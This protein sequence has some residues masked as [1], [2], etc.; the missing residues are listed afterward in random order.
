MANKQWSEDK[1]DQ[2]DDLQDKLKRASL[3]SNENLETKAV[4][5]PSNNT[6]AAARRV[7]D[8]RAKVDRHHILMELVGETKYNEILCISQEIKEIRRTSSTWTK[9]SQEFTQTQKVINTRRHSDWSNYTCDHSFMEEER[10]PVS[11]AFPGPII[12]I[13]FRTRLVDAMRV[14]DARTSRT[15]EE[16]PEPCA[17]VVQRVGWDALLEDAKDKLREFREFE[18][19][20]VTAD[21]KPS[22]SCSSGLCSM[23]RS[24]CIV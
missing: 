13:Y 18:I 17:C 11:K 12:D 6:A 24:R 14:V 16:C 19:M 5:Q 3:T 21:D 23:P 9:F 22:F 1:V 10:A 4:E 15:L 8:H 7:D 20:Y 2:H